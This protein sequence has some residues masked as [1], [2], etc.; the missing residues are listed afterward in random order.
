MWRVVSA[1]V[2]ACCGAVCP[3]VAT[4]EEPAAWAV[5]IGTRGDEDRGIY[6]SVLNA[7]E[8]T[9]S[10][11]EL[12]AATV[13]SPAFIAIH[14]NRRFLYAVGQ[15]GEVDGN[16]IGA[17]IAFAIDPGTGMLT[18]LN[19][20]LS[21]GRGPCHLVVDSAGR[22]VLVA[23]YWTGTAAV[24]PIEPDGRLRPVSSLVQH[25]GSSVHPKRQTAPHA[26]SINL[27]PANRFAVVADLGIDQVVVYRFSSEAGTL[28]PNTPPAVK[29]APGAGPRHFA[30]HPTGRF[31]YVINEL[32]STITAFAYD[33]EVSRL[34]TLHSVSTLPA[35]FDGTSATAEIVVH[36]SGKFVYGSNRGH[37][38]LAGFRVDPET[39]RLSP[40]GHTPSGGE[41]PR[42][43][44]IDPQ[45]RIVLSQ[46][47]DSNS[48]VVFRIDPE[49]GAL[50]PTGSRISVPS[51][52]CIRM[53]PH[54]Q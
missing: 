40:I 6:R 22:N 7:A 42:N 8:G 52:S 5:Y 38:S 39:G 46:N 12:A 17:V 24:L 43:F 27:D 14:P 49:T 9:L 4:A 44:A 54:G 33:A 19:K 1:M 48:V 23:N 32:D 13:A 50:E 11:P 3:T 47:L 26:H 35:G 18:E 16:P 31:A 51:P 30:F 36:P 28:T 21:G 53:I 29:M 37:D 15:A 20:Q 45:G 25:E 34:R 2:L 41:T 10:K